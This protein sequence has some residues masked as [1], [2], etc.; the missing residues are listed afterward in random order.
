LWVSLVLTVPVIALS[1]VPA[2]QFTNWQWL[3]LALAGPVV[4]YGGA[5]FHR[6]AAVNLRHGAATMDT[7]I[8]LGT[9]AAFGWSLWALF[10][11][12][13]GCPAC[14]KEGAACLR[15]GFLTAWFP[16]SAASMLL[17]SAALHQPAD[18]GHH[19]VGHLL[20]ATLFGAGFHAVAGVVIE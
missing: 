7:L 6:A 10:S 19:L 18:G 14:R 16:Y 1:M 11:V 8:S 12:P 9:L 20:A 17:G 2:W 13:P 4:G 5:P 3:A 15:R